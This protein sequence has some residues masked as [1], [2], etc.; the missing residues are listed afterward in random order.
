MRKDNEK[1]ISM[2]E[3]RKHRGRSPETEMLA[4][5]S[6]LFLLVSEPGTTTHSPLRFLLGLLIGSHRVGHFLADALSWFAFPGGSLTV[7]PV[8]R[9]R[10]KS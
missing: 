2:T 3:L 9:E 5:I 10:R 8:H 1:R 6:R 7:F 4:F